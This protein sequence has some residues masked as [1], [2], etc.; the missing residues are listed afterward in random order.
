VVRGDALVSQHIGD[1]EYVSAYEAFKST[2][3]DLAAMYEVNWTDVVVAHDQHPHY[4]STIRV[5]VASSRTGGRPASSGAY[6]EY[7]G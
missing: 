6:R 7:V 4:A 1:L 2:V 3:H 5:R